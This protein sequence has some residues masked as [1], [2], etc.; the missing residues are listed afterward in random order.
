M[1]RPIEYR[2][3]TEDKQYGTWAGLSTDEKPTNCITG[4]AFIAVDNGAVFFFDEESGNWLE[5]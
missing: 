3:A 2:Q 4:S 1:V 5:A